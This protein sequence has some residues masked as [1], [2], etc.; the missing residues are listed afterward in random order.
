VLYLLAGRGALVRLAAVLGSAPQLPR[1]VV[2]NERTTVAAGFALAEF[3][4]G[5]EIAGPVPGPQNAAAM[6]SDLVNVGT[7]ALSRVL[8][9]PPNGS[10]TSTLRTFNSLAAMA[11]IARNPAHN[12]ARL[13]ALRSTLP[14]TSGSPTT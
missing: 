6:T 5:R 4:A 1:S 10:Q 2:V 3:I 7:G 14:A 8:T 13:F 12:A 11:D 9:A